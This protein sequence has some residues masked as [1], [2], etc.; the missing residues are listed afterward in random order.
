MAFNI[1]TFKSRGMV[2]GGAR[3][4]LFEVV[5]TPPTGI[6]LN[7]AALQK[8]IFTCKS[9]ELPESTI[10]NIEIP[11]FGRRIK[12]AGERS[13]AD[14]SVTVMNDEDF[15]VRSMFEAWHNAINTIV[16]NVRLQS[17]SQEQ[18]KTVMDVTQFSK[19]GD[20]L[21]S[22]QLVG[23]FPTAVAGIGLG[24]DTQNSIEEFTVNFSYDYWLPL[25]ENASAKT[26][27]QV[28]EFL[29]QTE[30]GPQSVL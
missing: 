27:G 20:V 28:T 25:I 29:G 16:S 15:G 3:P 19:D 11:Y 7:P 23:A 26:A 5:L 2:Y 17:A 13:F 18:Y 10:S 4:S 1:S 22:Y 9:A 8:F 6:A 21:R 30:A 24:W 12:V 14:W